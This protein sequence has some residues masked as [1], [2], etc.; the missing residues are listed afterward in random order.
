MRLGAL[1]AVLIAAATTA[2]AARIDDGPLPNIDRLIQ[3][4][5][6]NADG[7]LSAEESAQV[8]LCFADGVVGTT[9]IDA[10]GAR[11]AEAPGSYAFRNEKIVLT[12]PS[13]IAWA[14]GRA[15]LICDIGVKP[16]VR[17]SLF[18]CVGSGQ[19][20]PVVFFDDLLFLAPPKAAS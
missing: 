6:I 4:C 9:L 15:T 12:G 14:F 18:D 13:D 16:Y 3:G 10:A 19:G 17:L 5:W 11:L 20:E 2:H 8:E 1:T 7:T